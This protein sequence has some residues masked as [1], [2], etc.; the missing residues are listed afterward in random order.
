MDAS[1]FSIRKKSYS[2]EI[3]PT[4]H[5]PCA[6]TTADTCICI[7]FELAISFRNSTYRTLTCT[8]SALDAG[9]I[10]NICHGKNLLHKIHKP[11]LD[12]SLSIVYIVI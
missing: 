12:N 10:N 9:I 4:G 5:P 8:R 6:G 1:P 7:D 2:S 11:V 3:A